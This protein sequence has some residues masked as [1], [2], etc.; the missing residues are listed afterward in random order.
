MDW[1]KFVE[2]PVDFTLWKLL[3]SQFL[4]TL[5]AA[6]FGLLLLRY[7]KKLRDAEAQAQAAEEALQ[8]RNAVERKEEQAE[9]VE[10][11]AAPQAGID[12]REDAKALIESAKAYM[13]QKAQADSDGRHV[14]TYNK[15]SGHHPSDLALALRDRGQL[16]DEK[17]ENAFSLFTAW[18]K[19]ARGRAANNRVTDAVFDELKRRHDALVT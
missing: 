10:A 8:V 16:S 9:A 2:I 13:E 18:K 19:Y 15:I 4:T 11:P 14:R 5:L 1:Q 6:G 17:F 12:R 3:D 7:E